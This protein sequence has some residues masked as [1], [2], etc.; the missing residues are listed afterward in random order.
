MS[1]DE[2]DDDEI[3]INKSE[4]YHIYAHVQDKEIHISCGDATQR[5]KWL[6]HVAIGKFVSALL[7]KCYLDYLHQCG[8]SL[9]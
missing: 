1:D 8:S 7:L 3:A 5:L 4:F 2:E 9:G 6:A